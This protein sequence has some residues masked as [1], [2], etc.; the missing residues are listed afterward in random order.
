MGRM[1][2]TGCVSAVIMHELYDLTLPTPLCLCIPGLTTQTEG[3][4]CAFTTPA[5]FNLRARASVTYCPVVRMRQHDV[6][7]SLGITGIRFRS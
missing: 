1:Q 2:L 5:G 4:V 3:R 7:P 6:R